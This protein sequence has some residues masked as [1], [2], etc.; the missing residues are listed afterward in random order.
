M[1]AALA[2]LERRRFAGPASSR[3]ALRRTCACGG[4]A[5]PGGECA[6][7]R[8]RRL[9]PTSA[10]VSGRHDYG[11]VRVLAT[12]FG[13]APTQ[14]QRAPAEPA[15][16]TMCAGPV[17]IFTHLDMPFPAPDNYFRGDRWMEKDDWKA[18]LQ[19]ASKGKCM[20]KGEFSSVP[21]RWDLG[22]PK[23]GSYY[24]QNLNKNDLK[25]DILPHL[26]HGGSPCCPCFSGTVSWSFDVTVKRTRGGTTEVGKTTA[27]IKGSKAGA[28]CDGKKC[29][30][31]DEKLRIGMS[32]SDPPELD[33]TIGG[34]ISLTGSTFE[35]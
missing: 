24:G 17:E 5:G 32:L 1:S 7:C 8:G 6:E 10:S 15:K 25:I 19:K 35:D 22:N 34:E 11:A 29:C 14:L 33:A 27:P 13:G 21:I 26:V 23:L 16:P 31:A 2:R 18:E 28:K 3:A 12:G 4:A 20:S 30:D 9:A